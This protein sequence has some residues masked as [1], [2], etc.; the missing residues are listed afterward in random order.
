[1][2]ASPRTLRLLAALALIGAA[3]P[4]A[5]G[6]V[7]ISELCDPHDN[8]LTDRFLEI[9]NAGSAAVSLSGWSLV[10]VGNAGDIFTWNLSGSIQP[11]EALVA[12]DATTVVAFPVDFAD[13]AWSDNNSLWNGKVG[14]GAKLLAPGGA[15]VDS[16][17][18]SGTTF[19][20][21]DYVRRPEIYQANPVY[22][23]SEWTA[24]PATLPTDGS[25]GTHTILPPPPGPTVTNVVTSP[26]LPTAADSVHVLADVT[27]S[28]ATVTSVVLAWGTS[29]SSLPDSI[30][31]APAGGS[32]WS[33]VAPIPPQAQ[34]TTVHFEIRATNDLPATTVVGFL[35]YEVPYEVSIAAV[36]GMAAASPYDGATVITGGVV[37]AVYP[38]TFVVQDGAGAW[39]G[40]WVRSS[41]SVARGDSVELRGI[42]TESDGANAGNTVLVAVTVLSSSPGGALPAATPVSTAALAAEDWEGVLVQVTSAACTDP[43]LGGGEW[44][45]DDGS[46]PGRVGVLGFVSSPTLGTEYDVTGCAAWA[47]DLRKLEPR[48]AA[49]V[50]WAGDSFAPLVASVVVS[51]DTSLAVTFTEP[52]EVLS[53]ETASNYAIAGLSV[54]GAVHN[55]AVPAEVALT[56]SAMSAGTYT[57]TV[58]GVED[59]YGNA[60]SGAQRDFDFVESAPPAG[61]YDAAEG[62][63]GA[64]LQAALHTIIAGH[65]AITYSEVW[66]AFPTT[67]DKPNGKVWDIYSDVPGGTP[68][69]EY[70]FGTDQGGVGGVEG[71]GYNREHSWPLGWYGGGAPMESDLFV[72]YPT[73]TYV[74]NRRGSEAYGEVDFPTWTSLNGSELGPCAYPG[75]SGTAFEPIDEYKGDLARSYFYFSTRYYQQDA[76]WPGSAMVSGATLLPWAAAMLLEWHEADPVSQKELDRNGTIFGIQANR[77]P[78]IDRPEFAERIWS[79][80]VGSGLAAAD[81]PDFTLG[82]GFPNPFG[83]RTVIP[84]TVPDRTAARLVVYDVTGRLVATL[85]DGAVEPGRHEVTWEGRA[86]DGEAVA[87]GVYFYRLEA[88]PHRQ[89]RRVVRLR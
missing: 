62:L 6:S 8:Y 83:P 9:Y 85:V 49:D 23:P 39:N 73:D 28:T 22:T 80:A 12:G 37:T 19:E 24:T 71:T 50:V 31:M 14:D 53:A 48:D 46:G 51:S 86:G 13:E 25:P 82:A 21:D 75:F 76:G 29:A 45:A 18:A 20:N 68:P 41:A 81:G 88:G 4:A 33:T 61:Y 78:F 84:F 34:G 2:T 69:Y 64:P 35:S 65:T 54:T 27:D 44:E 58:N 5:A 7:F 42:V 26:A 10:A 38:S 52:V 63:V 70:T 57:L 17:V 56:V 16:V 3:R 74:N 1:M 47:S 32:T 89:T 77:N 40:L 30:A 36:Q 79:P 66:D 43:V 11:G 15:L 60:A 72:V 87:P 59:L 55:G 67:D